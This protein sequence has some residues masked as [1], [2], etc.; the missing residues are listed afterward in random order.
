MWHDLSLTAPLV[1]T[2]AIGLTALLTAVFAAPNTS[3]GWVGH[4]TSLGYLVALGLTL[5][6]FGEPAEALTFESGAFRNALILDHFALALNAVILVGAILMSMA[7][8]DYLPSQRTDHGEYYALI[9]F[10]TAGMMALVMAAEL[11]T[12]FIAIE[13]MSIPLYI[14]AGFKRESRFSTESAMKYFVLGSFASAVLLMGMAF[15]Y[16]ATGDLSL[17]SIGQTLSGASDVPSELAAIGMVLLIAG[18]LFKIGAVPMHMW[19]PDVYEGAPA[20]ATGF[21]AIAVKTA[22]FGV[23]ARVLLTSFGSDDYRAG[24]TGWEMII[25]VVAVASMFIGN[26]AALNQ[27]NLKRVLAYSAIAHTGYLLLALLSQ[28]AGE[29]GFALNAMGA[30]L[31]FYLL[32]YTLANAAAFGVA[33]AISGDGR[34]DLDEAAY[35]GLAKKSPALAFV[36]AVAILSLLGIPLTAGF[37][38][39]LT[40]FDEILSSRGDEY[41]W[42]VIVAVVNSVISAWYYLRI[43]LVAFMKEEDTTRPVSLV[44]SRALSVAVGLAAT[45]T[46]LIGV[47]PSKPL[48]MSEQAGKSLALTSVPSIVAPKAVTAAK[49]PPVQVAQ[50]R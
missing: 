3:R 47:L 33:A 28:P 8:V 18:F 6:Q 30:G 9:A 27:K 19:T 36:L 34:E 11:L 41:L 45:A 35:A 50:P 2:V 15:T 40:I 43:L 4:L 32:A 13:L 14:L 1:I 48:G 10:S 29:G 24:D 17:V 21:M 44:S 46:L 38:G 16:G 25:A 12:V 22:S 23:F 26:L 31:G 39:K 20:T 5:L 49:T 7:S 37:M 42:L